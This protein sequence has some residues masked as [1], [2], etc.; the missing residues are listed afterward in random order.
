MPVTLWEYTLDTVDDTDRDVA[1]MLDLRGADGWECFHIEV[2]MGT[3]QEYR[4]LVFK[5]RKR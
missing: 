4:R 5:R 1:E 2:S 3:R